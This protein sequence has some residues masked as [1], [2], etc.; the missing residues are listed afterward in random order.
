MVVVLILNI[1]FGQYGTYTEQNK[2][3]SWVAT[4]NALDTVIIELQQSR[5]NNG[6]L[7]WSSHTVLEI[8]KIA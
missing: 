4:P 7:Y 6:Y 3:S 5:I 8:I 2:T 1:N